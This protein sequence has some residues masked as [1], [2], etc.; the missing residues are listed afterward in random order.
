MHCTNNAI[1]LESWEGGNPTNSY[2]NSYI[3]TSNSGY[4]FEPYAITM[5]TSA[6]SL[7]FHVLLAGVL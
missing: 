4:L 2:Y 6:T 1:Y 7:K 3:P 5:G